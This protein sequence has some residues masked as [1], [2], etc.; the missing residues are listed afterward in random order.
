MEE[1]DPT[2]LNLTELVL[3]ASQVDREAHRFLPR[4]V[5]EVMTLGEEIELPQRVLNKKRL[6]IMNYINAKWAAVSPI[7]NCPAKSRDPE[8]CF[9]CSN[10]QV[11][12]CTLENR[13]LFAKDD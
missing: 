3:I 5:L 12:C 7:V 4:E 10:F 2:Q 8:A 6:Q 9:T 11:A 13:K 1:F